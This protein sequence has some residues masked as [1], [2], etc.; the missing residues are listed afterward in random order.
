MTTHELK[1]PYDDAMLASLG[2]T[3]EEIEQHMRFVMAAKL[4]ELGELSSGQGAKLCGMTRVRFL[5][6]LHE[7]GV[8]VI[9]L[10]EDEIADEFRP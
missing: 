4:F 5:L 8:A 10:D 9:D 7:V 6:K 3:R 1:I 2:K